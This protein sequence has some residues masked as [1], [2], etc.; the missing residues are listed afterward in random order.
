MIDFCVC[1]DS[2]MMTTEG[3]WV[4]LVVV[5]KEFARARRLGVLFLT[6][7]IIL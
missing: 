3:F 6:A 5:D 4:F 2:G 7:D 1:V